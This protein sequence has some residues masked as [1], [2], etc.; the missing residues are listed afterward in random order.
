MS[1]MKWLA[2]CALV[3]GC[4]RDDRL[5]YTW[6]DRQVLCSD[7]IDNMHQDAPWHLV[8]DELRAARDERRVALFHAHAPG[9]TIDERA[10][11]H[12]LEVAD[13]YHLEYFTYRDLVPGR[14]RAGLALAFDDNAVDAWMSMRD[15]LAEHHAEVTFFVSRY[16]LITDQQR[17][18]IDQ[19]AADGNDIEPH[20]VMHLH[21]PKYVADHGLDAYMTDEALPSMQVLEAAGYTPTAYAYPF[22]QHTQALDDAILANV[23]HVRVSLGSCPY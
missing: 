7:T 5:A 16:S 1:A 6:D 10:I 23:A 18:E 2:A 13:R 15:L 14:P 3:A 19:L 20:S 21:A 4:M 22:G 9:A 8:E 12:V 11:R 17:A